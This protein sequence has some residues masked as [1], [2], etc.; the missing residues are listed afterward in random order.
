MNI[1]RERYTQ[2]PT[3]STNIVSQ[4]HLFHII[5]WIVVL[6]S[7]GS[8]DSCLGSDPACTFEA[9]VLCETALMHHAE[10]QAAIRGQ[11][12]RAEAEVCERLEEILR[13]RGSMCSEISSPHVEYPLHCISINQIWYSIFNP[14]EADKVLINTAV[15]INR[16]SFCFILGFFVCS[17]Y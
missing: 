12:D 2:V 17:V 9:V 13:S 4:N 3:L 10:A 5:L 15:H 14:E 6:I 8:V 7:V 16:L 1:N 11:V